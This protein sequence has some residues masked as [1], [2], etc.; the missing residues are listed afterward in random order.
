LPSVAEERPV[1]QRPEAPGSEVA[2]KE[3][4]FVMEI[5]SGTSKK[6][7]KFETAGRASK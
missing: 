6:E 2:P 4:A 5:I 1:R 7:N 3:P